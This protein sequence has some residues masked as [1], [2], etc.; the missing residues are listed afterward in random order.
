MNALNNNTN[1]RERVIRLS[2]DPQKVIKEVIDSVK[3]AMPWR[4]L[5]S[6]KEDFIHLEWEDEDYFQLKSL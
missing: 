6:L 4:G 1:E 3:G 2:V 5:S